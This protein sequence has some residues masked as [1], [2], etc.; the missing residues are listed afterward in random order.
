MKN[1]L[2]LIF[3]AFL[4]FTN[5]ANA[6]S[7][8]TPRLTADSI[9]AKAFILI[10]SK[11]QRVLTHYR[12]T[13][14]LSPASITKLMTAYVTYKAIKEGTLGLDDMT[15]ISANVRNMTEGSRMF[16]ERGSR[17]SIRDLLHG[18]VI[19]SGNDA[20][21]ALAEAVAG[22][23][24]QF[25][26]LM[27]QQAK[28]LGM[29]NSQFKNVTG[30]TADG[31]YVSAQDIAILAHAIITEFPEHYKLYK[32]KSFTWNNITQNNRNA[33]LRTDPSVD[34]LKTGYTDAAGYCLT[35][36]AKR[37]NM[38]LISVVL[39][40]KSKQAR[41]IASRRIL[42]YGF[43]NF[44]ERTIITAKKKMASR[45]VQNGVSAT[46]DIA[47]L[48]SIRLPVS[49][50]DQ[51]NLKAQLVL[52]KTLIA[53]ITAGQIVGDVQ[54]KVGDKVLASTPAITMNDI[55][56]VGFFTKLY[57]KWFN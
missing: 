53:P 31:H 14:R 42:N 47:A 51:K 20:A 26:E 19:Q 39:G 24:E 7:P 45:P 36:S 54:I 41:V 8:S 4:L 17:V 52:N 13:E 27:N 38:R 32:D 35:A 29:Y 1:I 46:V 12:A 50:D 56:E 37:D 57:R 6:D 48:G 2:S 28:K 49:R 11:S 34:G 18:L 30:L 22:S 43:N 9:G 55:E 16:L 21:V 10:D 33:L 5:V 3:T 15:I 44:V 40:T 25:I 23:E